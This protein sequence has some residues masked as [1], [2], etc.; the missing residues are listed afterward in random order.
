[1]CS[2]KECTLKEHCY[3][4]NAIPNPYRQ[5][6][7]TFKQNSRGKCKSFIKIEKDEPK[8]I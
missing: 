6:Y 8:E 5:S 4:F 3:R 7:D 2:N 1:M